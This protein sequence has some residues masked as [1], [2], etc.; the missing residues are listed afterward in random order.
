DGSIIAT[1]ITTHMPRNDAATPGQVCPGIRIHAID[2]VQPPGIAIPPIVDIDPHHRIVADTLAAKSS[3]AAARMLRPAWL[4]R[5]VTAVMA[6]GCRWLC[7]RRSWR[8]PLGR[9]PPRGPV[10][11]AP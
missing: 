11:R 9:P 5:H 8:G 6:C 4:S 3:V 10:V 1:I 7:R 2:I